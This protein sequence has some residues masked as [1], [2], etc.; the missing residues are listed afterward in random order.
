MPRR[1]RWDILGSILDAI[2][3]HGR[4]EGDRARVTNVGILANLPYDRL[5]DYLDDLA[6][7]G[8]VT[9][10]RMPKL[11]PQGMEFLDQ[12]RHW[13]TVLD[14]FGLAREPAR[15][16]EPA[17][18][19]AVDGSDGPAPIAASEGAAVAPPAVTAKRFL[20]QRPFHDA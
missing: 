18:G 2:D 13:Q 7:A 4:A 12:Y 6:K 3:T 17:P 14:R 19:I 5:Q 1:E 11:T 16:A 9:R 10:D 15:H 8:L 20:R